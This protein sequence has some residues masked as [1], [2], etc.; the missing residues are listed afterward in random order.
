MRNW[1]SGLFAGRRGP[2]AICGV[3]FGAGL[4]LS[5]IAWCTHSQLLGWLVYVPWVLAVVRMFSTN[6]ER[7]Y[8]ENHRFLNWWQGLRE[9]AAALR[10]RLR[11]RSGP[12]VRP[13]SGG[14][15]TGAG[16]YH[17]FTCPACGQKL[18]VPAGRGRVLVTCPKCGQALMEQA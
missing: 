5:V 18:R 15:A 8:Q 14:A 7:R 4:L 6:L 16:A 3:L 11:R 9:K 1:F 13:A 2:D 12:T 10:Q 17:H